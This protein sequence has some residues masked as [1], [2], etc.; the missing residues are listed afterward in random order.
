M[1]RQPS[2]PGRSRQE[3]HEKFVCTGQLEG[4]KYLYRV[5]A[6]A[7]AGVSPLECGDERE[8]E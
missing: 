4:K 5:P 6:G 8:W 2:Q 3:D 7:F 1:P